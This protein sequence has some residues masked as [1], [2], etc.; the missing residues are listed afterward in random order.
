MSIS[1]SFKHT[2]TK[3]IQYSTEKAVELLKKL[4]KLY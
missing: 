3:E 4:I 1:Y 2:L